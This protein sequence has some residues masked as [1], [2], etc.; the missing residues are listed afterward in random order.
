[1]GGATR[2]SAPLIYNND[3]VYMMYVYKSL[4]D[5]TQSYI[6]Y[7]TNTHKYL[8]ASN[9]IQ[10]SYEYNVDLNLM[11][12]QG[13]LESHFGSKGRARYTNSVFGVGAYDSGVNVYYFDTPNESIGP[14]ARY[15]AK[16]YLSNGRTTED[17]L[18]KGFVCIYGHRYAS[19][20]NYERMLM[21][22]IYNIGKT[23]NI[24]TYKHKLDSAL[25]A[26]TLTYIH[27]LTYDRQF[28]RYK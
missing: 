22:N 28:N 23:T 1:M 26:S 18:K 10:Y 14:Y 6:D 8:F 13:K 9:F 20:E 17:L 15:I 7:Y 16:R 5:E 12:S 25:D 11:L 4:K 3:I 27:I 21:Q 24:N 19:S 2:T